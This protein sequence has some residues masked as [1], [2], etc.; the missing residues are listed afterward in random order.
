MQCCSSFLFRLEGWRSRT[1]S[2]RNVKREKCRVHGSQYSINLSSDVVNSF[3]LKRPSNIEQKCEEDD[4]DLI[5]KTDAQTE[6]VME[7]MKANQLLRPLLGMIAEEDM[8]AIAE[9]AYRVEATAQNDIEVEPAFYIIEEGTVEVSRIGYEED[10]REFGPGSSFGEQALLHCMPEVSIICSLTA[11]RLWGI[12][13]S[14]LERVLKPPFERKFEIY[15]R[16]LGKVDFLQQ[17]STE[18]RMQL[19]DELEERT[20]Y[21]DEC[22]V[23]EGSAGSQLFVLYRGEVSAEIDGTEV[24]RLVGDP[25]KSIV[26]FIG[27]RAILQHE[28]HATSA[29]VMSNQ[30]Q[31]LILGRRVFQKLMMQQELERQRKEDHHPGKCL[32]EL[33][34]GSRPPSSGNTP[35]ITREQKTNAYAGLLAHVEL[36]RTKS[37]YERREL[38]S[39]V[40]EKTFVKDEYIFQQ[41]DIG[42]ACYVLYRGELSCEVRGSEVS[43]L[44]GEPENGQTPSFGARALLHYAPRGASI[45][46]FSEEAI[47]L[48]LDSYAF[49]LVVQGEKKKRRNSG[50]GDLTFTLHS[51][52]ELEEIGLLGCGG[53]GAVTLVKRPGGT[54]TFALKALSKGYVLNKSYENY[55]FNEKA[56]LKMAYSPF[57]TRLAATFSDSKY[58]Y[59]MLEPALGGELY[60]HYTNHPGLW[61]S[62]PH[63]RFCAACT[64]R[65]L[66]Y[67]H[68]RQIIYRD[69]KPENILLDSKGFC[70]V[71]DFSM[72]KLTIGHTYTFCG[73]PDYL[74]P[75]VVLGLG[76]NNAVDWWGLGVLTYELMTK[77]L[78]FQAE[79]IPETLDGI[80]AGFGAVE[81]PAYAGAWRDFV[82]SLCT[83][84]PEERLPLRPRGVTN[85]EEHSWYAKSCTRP[86]FDWAALDERTMK[87]PF[88]VNVSGPQDL[89]NFEDA[90]K[91][92]PPC[93]P[94]RDPGT[95]WDEGFAD[96]YGPAFFD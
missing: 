26:S 16:L 50:A 63:A 31:V 79:G 62:V 5:C 57:V 44:L 1:N 81:F 14:I 69:I 20:F 64:M 19:A 73:T 25:D 75:E 22:V 3:L 40:T 28:K 46:T 30:A 71:T 52:E 65:A 33:V 21:R 17:K 89:C 91:V 82:M 51:L 24:F 70:K 12:S 78:P 49:Q 9:L 77:K 76:Y 84:E 85:V 94:Y 36:F 54:Q 47:V 38:A 27:A 88:K 86:K 59:F 23:T 32:L 7:T 41:G 60:V 4:P 43:R 58:L 35:I 56:V 10:T 67:L 53:F 72:G 90:N 29:M 18:L 42:N 6:L 96:P 83:Y 8:L 2:N 34:Y 39:K 95:G 68:T 92:R 66:A 61:G 80:R 15:T 87:A 48:S 45:K 37:A 13:R 74:A 11:T 55:V 93:P